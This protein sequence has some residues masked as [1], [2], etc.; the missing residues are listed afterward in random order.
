MSV[1]K[2]TF[3][4]FFWTVVILTI[5]NKAT[6]SQFFISGTG[7]TGKFRQI[8]GNETLC[9]PKRLISIALIAQ[10]FL[11]H[12]PYVYTCIYYYFSRARVVKSMG[13]W[14]NWLLSPL[15]RCF[16][17]ASVLT[18]IGSFAIFLFAVRFQLLPFHWY[19]LTSYSSKW[20]ITFALIARSF[21]NRG[22][23]LPWL[24]L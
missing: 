16:F 15:A 2:T 4:S 20:L 22:R 6:F 21:M 7:K 24:T 14:G 13:N 17:I 19:M 12:T 5:V 1:D 23:F 18:F 9:R 3:F 10:P 8:G 11:T